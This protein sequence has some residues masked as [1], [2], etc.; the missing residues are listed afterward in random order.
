MVSLMLD[1]FFFICLGSSSFD[2]TTLMH[3]YFHVPDILTTSIAGL[4]GLT[5]DD[6]VNY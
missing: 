4:K 3:T 5:F 6:K 1:R 2:F